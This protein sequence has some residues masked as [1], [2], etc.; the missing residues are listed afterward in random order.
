M[1][2]ELSYQRS[3]DKF[4]KLDRTVIALQDEWPRLAFVGIARDRRQS[5]YLLSVDHLFVVQHDRHRATYQPD[6]IGLPFTRRL[7]GVHCW[8]DAAV[9]C[10]VAVR[11]RW[12]SVVLQDLYFIPAAQPDSA[13]AV[14]AHA[15]FR[16]QLEI[17]ERLFR[18]EVVGMSDVRHGAIS[19]RPPQILVRHHALPAC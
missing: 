15:K 9:Q 12:F 8:R 17:P 14:F 3:H 4:P 5:L 7:G 19:N 18:N 13:V 10:A 16:M 2:V 11:I 1:L 6:V